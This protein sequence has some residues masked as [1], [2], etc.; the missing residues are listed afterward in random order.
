MIPK[1]MVTLFFNSEAEEAARFYAATFPDSEVTAVHIAQDDYQGAKKGDVMCVEFMVA[2]IPCFG[3]N[4]GPGFDHTIAFSFQIMT[5]DQEET[6]R[7]WNAIVGNGGKAGRCCW[8]TDRWGISWQL[9][10][11]VFTE[12]MRQG[13]E[14]SRRL[15]EVMGTLTKADVAAFEAALRG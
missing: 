7:Y 8:C 1:N 9:T 5:E 10:P 13:G 14:V 11:R 12:G 4:G 15:G 2:G 6:D 3:I